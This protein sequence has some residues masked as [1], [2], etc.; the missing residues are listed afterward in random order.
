MSIEACPALVLNADFRPLSYFPLSLWSWQDAV[1]AVFLDRVN[2]V[3]QYDRVIRSP[4][5]EMRLPSV[6]SLKD[7]VATER[8]P[9][10]TRFNVFLRDRFHCQYCGGHFPTH[11]LTFDHVIPRS[12]GGRTTWE[13]VVTACGGCNLLKGS[14]L[15]REVGMWPR[16]RAAQPTTHLLQEHGRSFPPGYL[17]ESWRDFLYWDSEL[18][19]G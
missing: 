6:I 17:H 16:V 11:E 19:T 15:P 3:S 14:H 18:E 8:R 4:T 10:F 2:I 7:Y 9:A 12:R 1:K 13:N 5:F